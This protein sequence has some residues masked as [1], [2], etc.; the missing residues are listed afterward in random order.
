MPR[1]R[2]VSILAA[3]SVAIAG[4]AAALLPM[5]ASNAAAACVTAYSSSQVYT[6]GMTASYSSHN[7]QAKWWTQGEAPSTGGS[8]VWQDLGT[9]GGGGGG[10]GTTPTATPSGG[11]GCSGFS[12]VLS[13]QQFNTWFS[14]RAQLYTYGNFVIA[15]GSYSGFA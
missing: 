5:T 10:G 8:G 3:V 7:W 15:R 11:G 2:L 12:C 6:G 14:G 1:R 9:C 4:A 13:E